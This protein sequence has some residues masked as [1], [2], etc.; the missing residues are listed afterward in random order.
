MKKYVSKKVSDTQ[1]IAKVWV[2]G[3]ITARGE[4]Q[5]GKDSAYVIGLSGHLGAGKTAYVKC[6][7][8]EF[9][10]T[11]EVTSPT[12]VIMKIYDTNNSIFHR[13]V[14]IDA[15]RL[16]KREELGA[17]RFENIVADQHNLVLI[18]WPENVGLKDEYPTI[19]F[20]ID[21]KNSERVIEFSDDN[22]DS[23]SSR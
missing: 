12:Y 2:E 18:E 17:I 15:Y 19:S 22:S 9:G 4:V 23:V 14:H 8:K 16:E 20:H 5:P 11:S 6:V 7:A 21:E 3:I 1:K 13:I 10:I